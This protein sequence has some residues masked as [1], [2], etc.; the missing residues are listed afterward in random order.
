MGKH[1]QCIGQCE[2]RQAP[3]VAKV[4]RL[5]SGTHPP[6]DLCSGYEQWGGCT[7]M[8]KQHT[9]CMSHAHDKVTKRHCNACRA[10]V[11]AGR[12]T[13]P[14]TPPACPRRQQQAAAL[15]C[16]LC[17][18]A[19]VSWQCVCLVQTQPRG[20]DAAENFLLLKYC[21]VHTNRA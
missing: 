19:Y 8:G 3:W 15:H 9:P 17:A 20:L 10:A 4:Q 5:G 11:A 1:Q 16:P 6:M 21:D 12:L 13:P 18:G 14:Q 2:Q 7:A